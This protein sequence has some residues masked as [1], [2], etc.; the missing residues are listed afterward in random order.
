[1]QQKTESQKRT[2][3]TL[4]AVAVVFIWSGWIIISR[5]GV[6][7]VLSPLD[8]TLLRFGVATLLTAPLWL[9]L[10]WRT[11][12][13]KQSVCVALFTGFPYT[14]LSFY[15]LQSAKAAKAGVL[16][17]GLLPVFGAVL[18]ITLL[19]TKLK[20]QQIIGICIVIAANGVMLWGSGFSISNATQL[21]GVL[22]LI[23]ASLTYS[24][25]MVYV[26]A[27]KFTFKDIVTQV[28]LINTIFVL[29]IWLCVP[30]HMGEARWEELVLQGT[31]QGLI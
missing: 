3:A 29:P 13:L 1:M 19:K 30:S 26:K 21:Y 28:P 24:L 16:I 18:A 17:N 20:I 8:I 31:Y 23:L 11:V 7:S 12:N 27:W 9:R 10:D 5:L 2:L 22:F 4:G 25:Y 6:Q 15:G 14:M